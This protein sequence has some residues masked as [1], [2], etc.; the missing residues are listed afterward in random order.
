I[1]AEGRVIDGADLELAASPPPDL[2][3]RAARHRAERDVIERALVQSRGTVAG[4]ARLL[5]ISRPTLYGLL[6]IHNL[7]AVAE[8]AA[9]AAEPAQDGELS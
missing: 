2:D 4:A 7:A 6:D 3:L 8:P 1:M 9:A 5:G